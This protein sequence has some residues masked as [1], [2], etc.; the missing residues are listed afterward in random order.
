[1][2]TELESLKVESAWQLVARAQTP[3]EK[4]EAGRKA[5]EVVGHSPFGIPIPRLALDFPWQTSN[6]ETVENILV[7]LIA[8]DDVETPSGASELRDLEAIVG[9]PVEIFAVVARMS[10]VQPEPGQ[11]ETGG[12]GFYLSM[13]LS[14]DGGPREVINASPRQAVTRLWQV[15]CKD[16]FPV[17]GRFV[18]VGTKK[19]GRNQPVSFDVETK[20]G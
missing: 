17:F 12:W 18:Y 16:M 9:K 11:T 10:E 7:N 6:S 20:L 3:A 8:A 2:S 15:W 13:D 1:M 4:Y 5:I 19:Q 14:V